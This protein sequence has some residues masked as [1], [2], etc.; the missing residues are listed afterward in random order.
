M[1]SGIRF[2]ASSGAMGNSVASLYAAGQATP[3][4][5]IF[6]L[7]PGATHSPNRLGFFGLLGAPN[8]PVIV[9][10]FQDRTHRTDHD[11]NDLGIWVNGKFT[12]AS[13]VAISGVPFT[14]PFTAIPR[15]SGTLLLRFTEPNDALVVTQNAVF[16]AIDL[17]A[18]SGAPDVSNY[19]NNMTVQAFQLPDTDGYAGDTAWTQLSDPGGA[20]LTLEPQ[21]METT[22]HDFHIIVSAAAGVAGRKRD[23]GFYCQLEFL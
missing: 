11:G 15:E 8:S 4:A 3:K 6:A 22:V 1:V 10:Q 19:V 12:G 16:R 21:S 13:S 5:E 9:G 17:T 18:A 20:D 7:E 2:F 23:F 14:A